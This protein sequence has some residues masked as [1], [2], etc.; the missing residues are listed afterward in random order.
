MTSP[1]IHSDA[2]TVVDA[3]VRDVGPSIVLGLPLGLGKATAVVNALFRR[4]ARDRTLQLRIFTALTLEAPRGG[5]ELERRL[6]DPII[7]RTVGGYPV[8][9]YARAMRNGTLPSNIEINEFFLLAGRWLS[10]PL[11]QQSY[12]SAN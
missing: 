1:R 3:I 2:E 11:A 5:S 4:V 9:D 12:I 8:L 10:V 7:A 6:L